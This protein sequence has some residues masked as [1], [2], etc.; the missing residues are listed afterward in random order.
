MGRGL[1]REEERVAIE[2]RLSL[3]WGEQAT[4]DGS[5]VGYR[6]PD[7]PG[8]LPC[9]CFL[10]ILMS[11]KAI[12]QDDRLLPASELRGCV[13]VEVAVLGSRPGLPSLSDKPTASVDVKQIFNN[14]ETSPSMT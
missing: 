14:N 11:C 4:K 5:R 7:G 6:V 10:S 12:G 13:K 9:F 2:N 1:K 8:Y 3:S